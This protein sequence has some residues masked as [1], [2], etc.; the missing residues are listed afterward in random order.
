MRYNDS[1]FNNS[2]ESLN[3]ILDKVVKNLGIDRGL[4]QITLIN[5]WPQIVGHRFEKTSKA[6]SVTRKHDCDVMVVAV[7]S[8]SVS[9]ELVMFKN[10][11][12]KKMYPLSKALGFD[13]KD[14]I[15]SPKLWSQL[16]E[17]H[18]SPDESYSELYKKNP[19]EKDLE[20]IEVPESI[21]ES[22]IKSVESQSFSS[23]ELKRRME[24]MILRDLK[25]QI[26]K[27][28]NGYPFCAKCGIPVSYRNSAQETL[29]PACKYG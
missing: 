9:Q 15:F 26:W 27:K 12:I 22:V 1:S 25:V 18:F 10:D 20:G 6:V 7:S 14:V 17:E 23:D 11:I 24:K 2:F 16:H 28:N 21:A 13:I 19:D 8:S 5:F 3:N 29:C 4:K